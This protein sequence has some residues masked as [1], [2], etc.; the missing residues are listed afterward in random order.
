VAHLTCR[1]NQQP[2]SLRTVVFGGKQLVLTGKFRAYSPDDGWVSGSVS[3][4][5]ADPVPRPPPSPAV[6]PVARARDA[7]MEARSRDGATDRGGR[8]GGGGHDAEIYPAP[9]PNWKPFS[10]LQKLAAEGAALQSVREDA[11]WAAL[12][13]AVRECRPESD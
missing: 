1:A 2:E 10:E 11:Y 7:A 9:P 3:A 4:S 6:V 12:H 8:G 5:C 13:D